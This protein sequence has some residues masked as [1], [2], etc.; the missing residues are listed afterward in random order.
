MS[1]KAKAADKVKI[2]IQP[3]AQHISKEQ[4]QANLTAIET[5][6]A[7]GD[8]PQEDKLDIVIKQNEVIIGL[9]TELQ[10]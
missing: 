4:L 2:V 1:D 8:L 7:K 5:S 10:K 6:K 3:T 9:L